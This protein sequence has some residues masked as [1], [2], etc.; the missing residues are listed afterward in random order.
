LNDEGLNPYL[1]I[2]LLVG[3]VEMVAKV[4]LRGQVEKERK[5]QL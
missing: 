5:R 3:M 1:I 4:E 2:I